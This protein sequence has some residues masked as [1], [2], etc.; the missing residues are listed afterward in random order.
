MTTDLRHERWFLPE[1]RVQDGTLSRPIRLGISHRNRADL[2]QGREAQHR[3]GLC[4]WRSRLAR[5]MVGERD[6]VEL[7][8]DPPLRAYVIGAPIKCARSARDG[9]DHG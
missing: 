9:I 8:I 4:V 5:P 2:D 6:I 7:T 3:Q 1:L